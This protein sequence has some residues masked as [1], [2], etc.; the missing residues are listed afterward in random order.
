[1]RRRIYEQLLEWE[2]KRSHK[3]A[4]LIDNEGYLYL[5]FNNKS[6]ILINKSACSTLLPI[7]PK[8]ASL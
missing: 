8:Q 3:E 1:M 7:S 5:K 4:L 2:D 6:F